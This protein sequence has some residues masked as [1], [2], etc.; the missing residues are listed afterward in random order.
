MEKQYS[1]RGTDDIKAGERAT[2]QRGDREGNGAGGPE[3][4]S[5][6]VTEPQTENKTQKSTQRLNWGQKKHSLSKKK[7][8]LQK[9]SKAP[10]DRRNRT[11]PA[12]NYRIDPADIDNKSPSIQDNI[13]AIKTLIR[14]ETENR[15][16]TPAEQK[17]LAQYK[18]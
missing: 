18:G 10:R 6:V 15:Q 1:E 12:K 5:A 14:I 16:A 8:L 11:L 17:I 9:I 2:E 7:Q 13:E 3:E 4:S